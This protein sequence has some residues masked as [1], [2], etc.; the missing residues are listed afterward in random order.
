MTKS[1]GLVA[2]PAETFEHDMAVN[3]RFQEFS[4]ELLRLS[5]LGITAVAVGV[6]QY[7]FAEGTTDRVAAAAL[8][9]AAPWLVGAL[10][11]FALAA[12]A[13]LAHRY[14]S[15]DSLSWHLQAM[16]RYARAEGSDVESADREARQR[17]RR[18]RQSRWALQLSAITLGVAAAVFAG[19]IVIVLL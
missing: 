1:L 13:A 18:F 9:A 17:L 3:A 6:A 16:R 14:V 5:L 12:A 4:A 11:L 8:R 19:G 2:I 15:S 7:L 10:V